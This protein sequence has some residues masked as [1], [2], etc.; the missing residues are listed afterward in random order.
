[1]PVTLQ[2]YHS[3]GNC[4]V[5]DAQ[6]DLY[7]IE[8][9]FQPTNQHPCTEEQV[10]YLESRSNLVTW[11]V[12]YES[13]DAAI[14]FLADRAAAEDPN[15]PKEVDG[16]T[17]IARYEAVT[18]PEIAELLS[19]TGPS[20]AEI[21][22]A[23]QGLAAVLRWMA[24]PIVQNTPELLDL[25]TQAWERW[26]E[27]MFADDEGAI[28]CDA[29][30]AILSV[31]AI[32]LSKLFAE[33]VRAP[34]HKLVNTQG[35]NGMDI[36]RYAYL[37]GELGDHHEAI[38]GYNRFV[39]KVPDA[40]VGYNN[41]GNEYVDIGAFE[42]ALIDYSKAIDLEPGYVSAWYNRASAYYDLG[43]FEMAVLDIEKTLEIDPEYVGA[44][45]LLACIALRRGKPREALEQV[46]K[47]LSLEPNNPSNLSTAAEVH[48]TLGDTG[49]FYKYFQEALDLD[50]E[51][52]ELLDEKV[53]ERH[54]DE[55]QFL[56]LRHKY[57]RA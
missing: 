31:A 53:F 9:P 48:S 6:G 21:E 1:L 29:T 57:P 28:V 27:R 44:F 42:K 38:W 15:F 32:T 30:K 22:D 37:K 18:P 4:G 39:E 2:S 45:N 24:M 55:K 19:V 35:I 23:E 49:L 14:A 50:P 7:F 46:R 40:E 56:Q 51:Q 17:L 20:P 47:A 36:F 8:F 54:K 10:E 26:Q 16:K 12:E 33:M 25:A 41:R 5:I 13:L 52:M 43:Q 11:P 34:L 3:Y